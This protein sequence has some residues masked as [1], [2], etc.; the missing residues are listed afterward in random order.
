MES[1][2]LNYAY[3]LRKLQTRDCYIFL[4]FLQP[5]FLSPIAIIII[6]CYNNSNVIP[7]RKGNSTYENEKKEMVK[8]RCTRIY[9]DMQLDRI[10]RTGEI[11]EVT[12]ERGE[13]LVDC[14]LAEI[15]EVV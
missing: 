2:L 7:F 5:F 6:F 8:V 9:Q 15:L 4:H 13:H 3:L 1:L 11:L 12:R 10:V 14:G